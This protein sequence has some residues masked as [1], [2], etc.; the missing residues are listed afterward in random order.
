MRNV[1][2]PKSAVGFGSGEVHWTVSARQ[3]RA[4]KSEHPQH[5]SLAERVLLAGPYKDFLYGFL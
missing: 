3:H 1:L 4:A 5:G 2:S